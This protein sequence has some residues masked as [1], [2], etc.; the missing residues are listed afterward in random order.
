[1][2][3]SPAWKPAGQG[4]IVHLVDS[5]RFRGSGSGWRLPGHKS[6]LGKRQDLKM[7]GDSESTEVIYT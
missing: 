7:L 2:M 6:R 1:M 4:A 3:N 5:L